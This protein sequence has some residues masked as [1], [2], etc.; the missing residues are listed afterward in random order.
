VRAERGQLERRGTAEAR[1]ATATIATCPSSR[2][3]LKSFDGMARQRSLGALLGNP[4]GVL[5]CHSRDGQVLP[6]GPPLPQLP[7]A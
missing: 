4:K 7:G 5:R 1:P 6:I 3:G 2:P